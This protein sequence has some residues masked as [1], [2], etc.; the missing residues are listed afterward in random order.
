[1]LRKEAGLNLLLVLV[2]LLF[3]N[4][5][6]FSINVNIPVQ[7]IVSLVPSM[8]EIL[9]AIGAGD[10]VVG[11]TY[12]DDYPEAVKKLP[13]VGDLTNPS[14]E[15]ILEL[16]PDLVLGISNLH[17]ELLKRLSELGIPCYSLKLYESLNELYLCIKDLGKFTKREKE[18][19]ELRERVRRELFN[20]SEKGRKLKKHPKVF[21]VIWDSPLATVSEKSYI[22]ELI[23]IAGGKN[24]VSN[25][26]AY[27]PIYSIEYLIENPPDIVIVI[28]GKGGMGVSKERFLRVLRE[29]RLQ[30]IDEKRVFE[31]DGDLLFRLS[32]RVVE[33]AK[34]LYEVFRKWAKE[35]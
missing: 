35:N 21:I 18:A 23:E 15:K 1:M 33:G 26:D 28:G 22:S 5:P 14:I 31:I 29:R 16:K 13:K 30:F 9:F 19:K 11:V 7:R 8:T 10:K 3:S 2:V 20:L 34:Q 12:F 27:F 6:V 17:E 32:P 24:M 25:T 4:L